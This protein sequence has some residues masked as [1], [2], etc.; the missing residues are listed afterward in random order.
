MS[1]NVESKLTDEQV[2]QINESLE[3]A[4]S[5]N[6]NL[7]LI[8]GLP[9]NNGIDESQSAEKGYSQDTMVAINPDNGVILTTEDG[10]KN[11]SDASFEKML[12]DSENRIKN[13]TEEKVDINE[14]DI[15]SHA[16]NDD[17]LKE[18]DLS[19]EDVVQILEVVKRVQNKDNFSIF[20]SL[21]KS[22]QDSI[23]KY[24]AAA[25]F[26]NY[27]SQSNSVR[28]TIAEMIINDFITNISL[29]KYA[30]D[31]QKEM[32]EIENQ[33]NKEFSKMFLDYNQNRENY[34]KALMEKIDDESKK[35]L[36]GDVLDAVN[37][38]YA[39]ERIKEAARNH[40]IPRIKK[41]DLDKPSRVFSQFNSKYMKSTYNIYSIYTACKTLTRHM[42]DTPEKDVIMFFV[43]IAK[44]CLNYSPENAV[45]H[46]FMYYSMYNPL[47]LDVYKGEVYD[48]FAS[49]YIANVKE[50]IDLLK[51]KD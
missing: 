4:R 8:K 43:A 5:E 21:P 47:L 49:Q 6:S 17:L 22:V 36:V 48:Q 31:F 11:G 16:K 12:K 19:S 20:K 35:A 50:V 40:K 18:L 26:G 33:I 14:E 42:K 39:L 27:S 13:I 30:M 32:N 45:E 51:K 9:S 15:K 46:A 3:T 7:T 38:G 2:K 23:Q 28:N 1:E 41:F 10:L 24:V 44:Y 37:D 25:G 34:I 29:E